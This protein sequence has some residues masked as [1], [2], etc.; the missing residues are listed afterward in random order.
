M[1]PQSAMRL[2]DLSD[3]LLIVIFVRAPLA[4]HDAARALCEANR[5][6]LTAR[7][8]DG[9]T[10]LHH[11]CAG[12]AVEVARFV[13]DACGPGSLG[14]NERDDHDMTPFHLACECGHVAVVVS[15]ARP[16]GEEGAAPVALV[17]PTPPKARIHTFKLIAGRCPCRPRTRTAYLKSP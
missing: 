11:A 16:N 13:V 12:G 4:C 15:D 2:C 9:Q 10:C 7:D 3:D 17:I 8:E 6:L 5:A 14:C 1:V